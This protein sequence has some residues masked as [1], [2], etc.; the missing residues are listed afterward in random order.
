MPSQKTTRRQFLKVSTLISGGL[1]IS[2]ATKSNP[3]KFL[4][5]VDE[6]VPV[7]FNPFLRISSD[8]TI[9]II[10]SKVEM[11]QGISTTLPMLMAEELDCEWS[12]IKVEHSAPGKASDFIEP[13]IYQSSGGSETTKS[14]FGS[15]RL[16]GATA[17]AMLVEAAAKRLG[18]RPEECRTENSKVIAGSRSVSY[19]EIAGEASK[20]S[21]PTVKLVDKKEWKVIGKPH[22][23]LNIKEMVSGKVEYGI[24]I[25][26]EGLLTA[27][28]A[29]APVFGGR[30]KS[31]DESKTKLVAGVRD[32]V[33]I[34]TGVAVIAD[35]FWS[36]KQGKDALV[37][38]WDHG[39]NEKLNT[40]DIISNYK[41]IANSKGMIV[42]EKGNVTTALQSVAK[43][44]EAEYVFPY[45][46]HA[47]MEPLNCTVKLSGN[48]CEVWAATQ[49]PWLH[50]AEIATFL[51]LKPEDVLLYTP[52]MGGSF[53]RR[54]SFGGDWVIEGVHIAKASGKP[55]KLVWTREDDIQGGYY[56]PIYVHKVHVGVDPSGMPTAWQHRIVGQSLFENT[57]LESLIV[58]NGIDYSSVT[59]GAPYSNSVN[60][61]SFELHTTRVGVPVLPWRAVGSTHN[62]FVIETMIDELAGLSSIDPVEYRR[63]FLKDHPRHL[64]VLNMA[65]ERSAWTK[66]LSKDRFRGISLCEAM[67][68]Y[69]CQVVEITLRD[70]TIVVDRVVCVIDCGLVVNA[71][72]V[73]AQ[74]EGGIIFGLTAALYG[75]ISI[76]NGR[77]KQQNFNNY[78][79]LRM[80]QSPTIEVHLVE[81]TEKI[82]GAGEP[83]VPNV[84][85]A[86][87]NAVHKATGK[88]IRRLPITLDRL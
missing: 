28:V 65:A 8:N 62:V 64:G 26:F 87:A 66:P 22:A 10:L 68:S 36:A 88:R 3:I 52:Q 21:I 11:G 25:H 44:V 9:H 82:T 6:D 16:A 59:T 30:V 74:M 76:E 33:Q 60:D 55:I 29:H 86:L 56:R 38:E 69:V 18:V 67:G 19:G 2:V 12:A 42:S 5:H 63:K 75:E 37:I 14:Q 72:G 20:L 61:Y 53:G 49:S 27:V 17:R 78:K 31:F 32:V 40:E 41:G 70:S 24:D 1:L 81:S 51:G 46:A 35:N 23:R 39:V 50:Q 85:P 71:D 54:G 58:P 79:L 48:R 15:Y 84:A 57:P 7:V 13:P 45:L 47:P 80:G 43:S 77:V 4:S 73:R 83:G 34:P